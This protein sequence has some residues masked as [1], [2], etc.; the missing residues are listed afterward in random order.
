MGKLDHH[1]KKEI[2]KTLIK[3]YDLIDNILAKIE[4][5]KLKEYYKKEKEEISENLIYVFR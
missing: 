2:F 4:V 5:I 1:G 3:D